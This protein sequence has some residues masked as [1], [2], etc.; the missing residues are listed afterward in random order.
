[1]FFLQFFLMK[2]FFFLNYGC[3]CKI[4]CCRNNLMLTTRN[5]CSGIIAFAFL[6]AYLFT[7]FYIIPFSLSSTVIRNTIPSPSPLH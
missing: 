1:M 3:I 5:I 7:G 6:T 2:A 4:C